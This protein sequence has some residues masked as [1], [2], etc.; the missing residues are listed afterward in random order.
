MRARGV[1]RKCRELSKQNSRKSPRRFCVFLHKPIGKKSFSKNLR[2]FE[3]TAA[4][5]SLE[6]VELAREHK[7]TTMQQHDFDADI[8]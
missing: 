2:E 6:H 1:Q 7:A 3:W 5:G 4:E 8:V